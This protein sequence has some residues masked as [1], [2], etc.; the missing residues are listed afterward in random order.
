M[1]DVK[2]SELPELTT[3]LTTALLAV[4]SVGTTYYATV[5]DVL[6]ALPDDSITFAKFQ[7]IATDRLLGRDS[8]SSGD[9]EEISVG[10][11]LEFTGS[12][13]IQRSALTGDVTAAA[14]SN[15][16]AIGA[17]VIVDAD[18]NANAAITL[19]KLATQAALTVVANATNG[20]AVPTAIAAGADFN[21]FRRSGTALAFGP[22]DLSQAGAVGS[23]LLGAAN[24][25][26]GSARSV[27][28]RATN[29]SGV[30]AS[31]A[32]GGANTVL[33][34][35]GTTLS[36]VALTPATLGDGAACSFLGR[37]LNSS[38]VRADISVG[39]NDH[40]VKRTASVL[41]SGFIVD[42][43]VD[44]AAAIAGTKI[45]PNFGTTA[46]VVG[47]TVALGAAPATNGRLMLP[48]GSGGGSDGIRFRNG[49]ND[50]NVLGLALSS[51]DTLV[52]GDATGIAHTL[53]A[54]GTHEFLI[55]GAAALTV[56]ATDAD[57]TALNL[58]TTG[59][60]SLTTTGNISFG[61]NPATLG[62]LRVHHDTVV[63]AGRNAANDAD[64][65]LVAWGDNGDD[66]LT[67][68]RAGIPITQVLGDS[69]QVGDGTTYLEVATLA[70][71]REIVSL[72]LGSALTTTQMPANTGDKVVYWAD[73]TTMPTSGFPTSGGIL[74]VDTAL[75]LE[76]KGKNGVE[77]TLAPHG[78]SGNTTLRR[79]IDWKSRPETASDS[80]GAAYTA[81]SFD[82]ASFNGQ[83]L[84]N[85]QLLVRARF[86]GHD[87]GSG[88]ASVVEYAVTVS[89][90]SGTP[91][92][93][94]SGAD[95]VVITGGTSPWTTIAM[96]VSGTT[97]RLRLTTD[98]GVT[99][100]VTSWGFLEVTGY[101]Y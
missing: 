5:G 37:S 13:G 86:M 58:T 61:V 24:F 53:S 25:A 95:S 80:T 83:G 6:A 70:T 39:T 94:A 22:I 29:S 76:W 30:Q 31:I 44:A 40:V 89:V 49:A 27:F 64:H 84:T 55:G 97:V 8:A 66:I 54:A 82:V 60:L 43:N 4:V 96:D 41:T 65:R 62:D 99:D 78:D 26:D 98:A 21:V 47:G 15:T 79:L 51:G 93:G 87:T 74:G 17:G 23:S 59:S 92:V 35:N 10:G 14:G 16:T 46:G 88:Y 72:L 12:G 32:G 71:D 38:G 52:L 48:N 20:T 90:A 34:D 69:V 28:G 91:T 68:G 100:P 77:T 1:A 36:F 85:A 11:G 2:I 18:V 19:S 56:D 7:D 33:V 73:A 67:I 45:N 81:L 63:I 42:A 50:G 75:G 57:F 3:V 9:V 101:A